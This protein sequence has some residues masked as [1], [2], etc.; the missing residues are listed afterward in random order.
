MKY[1]ATGSVKDI[2]T[3]KRVVTGYLSDFGTK[4]SYGDVVLPNAFTKTL[5]DR[6]DKIFFLN[7]HDWKQPLSKFDVLVEDDKGL[8]F[9]SKKLPDTT[10]AN[11]LLKLYEAGII[12]EHSFGYST[13]VSEWNNDKETNY[14]KELKLY[15]GSAVT[16]GANPNTPF[17]GMKAD[18]T[19]REID[20][21]QYK[22]IQAVKTGTFT[23]ET[24]VLLEIALKQLQADAYQLGKKTLLKPLLDNTLSKPSDSVKGIYDFIN[25]L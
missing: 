18:M 16:R 6:K 8:Y 25:N 22:I 23:D 11:D 13:V 21:Q 20:E 4:D 9:E 12:S 2:D 14:L 1:K 15:E 3:Y 5:A 17:T 10:Y 24:F 19:L 7:Q